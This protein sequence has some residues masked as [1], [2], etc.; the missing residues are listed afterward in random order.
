V[1]LPLGNVVW[2][3]WRFCSFSLSLTWKNVFEVRVYG[4]SELELVFFIMITARVILLLRL[5]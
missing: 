1:L 5:N 4:I 2:K 3:G